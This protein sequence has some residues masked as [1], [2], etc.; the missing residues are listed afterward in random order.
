MLMARNYSNIDLANKME[1]ICKR[2]YL[3]SAPKIT[4]QRYA[5]KTYGDTKTNTREYIFLNNMSQR[6]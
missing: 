4:I 5:V 1:C 3:L 2:G 6:K